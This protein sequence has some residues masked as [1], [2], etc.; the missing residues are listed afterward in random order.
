MGVGSS[1]PKSVDVGRDAG[2]AW[3]GYGTAL[4]PAWSPILLLR[5]P[6]PLPTGETALGYGT[7]TLRV[8]GVGNR[9]PTNLW[10]DEEAA[11][12]VDVA[13]GRPVSRLF[14]VPQATATSARP[15][16]TASYPQEW[17]SAAAIPQRRN[18]PNTPSQNPVA[19]LK[20]VALLR[21][22]V[23]LIV[24]PGALVLDP[25]AGSGTLGLAVQAEGE[26][27]GWLL[28]E[29]DPQTAEVR[30][31]AARPA[32]SM[33]SVIA[34]RLAAPDPPRRRSTPSRSIGTSSR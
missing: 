34:C 4:R 2:P 30:A 29:R 3:A 28:I 27:R 33:E 14:Y 11:D 9:W 25:F 23:R 24:P 7:G 1:L 15:G 32:A 31:R 8:K 12:L 6:S 26:G 5:K 20:P 17:A 13:T 22:L 21:S 16:W 18:R 19:A 10:L